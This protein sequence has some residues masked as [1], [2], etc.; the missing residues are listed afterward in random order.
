MLS[1]LL[2]FSFFM[3]PSFVNSLWS[4]PKLTDQ[5]DTDVDTDV[6]MGVKNMV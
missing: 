4:T 5:V 6:E 2:D 1:L 3:L